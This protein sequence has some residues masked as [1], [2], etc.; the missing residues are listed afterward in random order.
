MMR[1]LAGGAFVI[2][3][4]LVVALGAQQT[5]TPPQQPTFRGGVRAVPVYASVTDRAGGFVLDLTKD[6]FEIR[7]NGKPQ[8][9]S[10]FTTDLQPIT[11]MIMIDGS[12]S[13]LPAF[14]AVL[15]AANAF[16]IRM[17]PT[18]RT[19]IGS[20]ADQIQLSAEYTDNRDELLEFLRNQ[21]N[22][23]MGNETRLW[24]A[25][26]RSVLDL[27]AQSG[28]RVVLVFSDGYDTA[29][30][31]SGGTVL[32]DALP[33]DVTIYAIAMWVGRGSATTRPSAGLERLA[34][35]TGGGFYELHETDEMNTTF[36][37][38]AL[39][40]HQQYLMAFEPQVLDGKVHKLDVRLKRPGLK[41]RA[42]G[43][44]VAEAAK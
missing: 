43:S 37:K 15:D 41:V 14:D 18:D 22:L 19:R 20:F 27:G 38:I 5:T 7:D 44:Y 8:T 33:R 42:R 24:D 4:A 23:R 39:E 30:S 26:D 25:I 35:E 32:G 31:V 40:L 6:D 17:L 3:A 16:V 1:A 28:R 10:Q 34:Q 11:T 29:S 13:M 2:A 9:I 12:G 36:T 21:F